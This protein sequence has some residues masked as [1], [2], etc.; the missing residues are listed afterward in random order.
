MSALLQYA[1]PPIGHLL[2][3]FVIL[4]DSYFPKEAKASRANRP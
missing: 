4:V 2:K 3:E 1:E